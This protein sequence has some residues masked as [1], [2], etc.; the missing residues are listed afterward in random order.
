LKRFE[1]AGEGQVEIVLLLK[2]G[3]NSLP[4]EPVFQLFLYPC[5]PLP[6]NDRAFFAW[7]HVCS[8][9]LAVMGR[10][11][12]QRTGLTGFFQYLSLVCLLNLAIHITQSGGLQNPL[13]IKGFLKFEFSRVKLL[14]YIS[15]I[16]RRFCAVLCLTKCFTVLL[17]CR[18]GANQA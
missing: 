16:F 15:L 5:Q 4:T 2:H 8:L 9:S 14:F 6:D 12:L 13:K 11:F 10:C 7:S 1:E 18:M 3:Q 17:K